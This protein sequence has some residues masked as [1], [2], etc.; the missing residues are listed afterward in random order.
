VSADLVILVPMLGRPHRV[1]P[2]LASTDATVPKARVLF[3][4]SP[5]DKAVLDE[6]DR[7]G[8][9][10]LTVPWAARG[11]YARKIN[12]GYRHTTEPHIFTGADDLQFHPG[13]Y[14]AATAH[15]RPGI[16]VVGTNDLGSPRVIAGDHATHSLV[17]REYA[18]R[19]GT[20]DQPGAILCEAYWHEFVDDELVGTAK[21]RGAFAMALDSKVAHLHPN[22]DP[23]IPIDGL[24]AQ[25]QTRMRASRPLYQRRRQ[26]W[27]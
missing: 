14:E 6:V 4:L 3:C 11:D 2:L 12:A 10:W 26:L 17:T 24:Y 16:G 9:E 15:L 20:I 18:D 1:Q 21:R 5:H 22:W 8:R 23:S 19:H 7:A 13:W 25:Q 27:A